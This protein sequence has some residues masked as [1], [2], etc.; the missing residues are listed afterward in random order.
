MPGLNEWNDSVS[1][2][3]GFFIEAFDSMFYSIADDRMALSVGGTIRWEFSNTAI[4]AGTDGSYNI[5]NPG[6]LR[7]SGLFISGEARAASGL[8][9]AGIAL[10]PTVSFT[11]D[12]NTG[13]YAS[14]ADE[15]SFST[16]GVQRG[17]INSAGDLRLSGVLAIG[18]T[19]NTVSPS[20][21]NRTITMVIGGTTYYISAKTTN[22]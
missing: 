16:G 8:F 15:L 3:P 10:M 19:V 18:N 4:L 1:L 17:V 7:P 12:T 22:D 2:L 6:F 5:G 11:G 14:A 21:P 13:M 20:A 9:G